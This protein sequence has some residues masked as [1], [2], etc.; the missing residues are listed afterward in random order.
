MR[1]FADEFQS[2]LH[3][4]F[5]YQWIEDTYKLFIS[6]LQSE[7][8]KG[9]NSICTSFYIH[10][11]KSLIQNKHDTEFQILNPFTD[12]FVMQSLL[13]LIS[14]AS[15]QVHYLPRYSIPCFPLERTMAN[16][17]SASVPRQPNQFAPQDSQ[18]T[19][20]CGF[21]KGSTGQACRYMRHKIKNS[22][23]QLLWSDATYDRDSPLDSTQT[24]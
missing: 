1:Y 14:Q 10:T 18:K 9:I 8:S 21:R 16:V 7:I 13:N 2:A 24:I 22:F 23:F 12:E 4:K 5:I 19:K 11:Y 15:L 3:D 20:I 6:N 17:L